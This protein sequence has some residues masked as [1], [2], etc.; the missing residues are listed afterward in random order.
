MLGHTRRGRDEPGFACVV[1]L[2]GPRV[3]RPEGTEIVLASGPLTADGSIPQDTAAW[4]AT[5]VS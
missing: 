4:L 5:P 3:P 2:S 1:N